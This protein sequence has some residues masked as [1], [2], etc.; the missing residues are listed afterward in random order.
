MG[1]VSHRIGE[2][3]WRSSSQPTLFISFEKC[4]KLT[5]GNQITTGLNFA[6]SVIIEI[7]VK[8]Q[9]LQSSNQVRPNITQ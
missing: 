2:G 5:L 6:Y 9:K 3:P 4:W 8:K 7:R 1:A